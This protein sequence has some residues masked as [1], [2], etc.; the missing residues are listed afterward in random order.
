M[1]MAYGVGTERG[2]T[3]GVARQAGDMYTGAGKA[4][5]SFSKPNG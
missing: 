3:I 1:A 2:S 4:A 5:T